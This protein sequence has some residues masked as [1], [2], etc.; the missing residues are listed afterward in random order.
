VI[1]C[2]IVTTVISR[3]TPLYIILYIYPIL[4][5]P[6]PRVILVASGATSTVVQSGFTCSSLARVV[7]QPF[8]VLSQSCRKL[9]TVEEATRVLLLLLTVSQSSGSRVLAP[10]LS[11]TTVV[12]SCYIRSKHKRALRYGACCVA[13]NTVDAP[14]I[15]NGLLVCLLVY[16]LGKMIDCRPW[17]I[18]YC[19][20]KFKSEPNI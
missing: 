5:I 7:G 13:D 20:F 3:S 6:R 8:F 10:N 2:R 12:L 17:C 18:L 11:I 15:L 19:T 9:A 14:T 1:Y 4:Y 16:R